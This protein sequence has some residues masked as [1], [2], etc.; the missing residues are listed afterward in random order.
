MRNHWTVTEY[1]I[2]VAF[3]LCIFL[4]CSYS[5]I[6]AWGPGG[7][8]LEFNPSAKYTDLFFYQLI[9]SIE[10]EVS[11][12]CNW[13]QFIISNLSRTCIV[14]LAFCRTMFQRIFILSLLWVLRNWRDKELTTNGVSHLMRQEKRHYP[15]L[16][17][18][19]IHNQI[20]FCK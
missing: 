20:L 15:L 17:C 1:E 7:C 8:P 2:H 3:G 9:S 14:C 11:V 4:P 18:V 13:R 19:Q 6:S 10:Y 12:P 16:W 5:C